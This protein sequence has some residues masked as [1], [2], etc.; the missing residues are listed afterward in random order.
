V[1]RQ[2]VED[3]VDVSTGL[4][5]RFDLAQKRDEVLGPMLGLAPGDLFARRHI[6][7]GE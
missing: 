1:R 6:Q 2:I 7:R 5:A 4:D 3:D